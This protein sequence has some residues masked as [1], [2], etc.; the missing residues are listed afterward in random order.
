MRRSLLVLVALATGCTLEAGRGFAT[1]E[2]GALHASLELDSEH[3]LGGWALRTD[4]GYHVQLLELRVHAN[5][6]VLLT[7]D[8]AAQRAAVVVS[9]PI[10][11]ELD[12]LAA[13]TVELD[14]FEPSHELGLVAIERAELGLSR[15]VLEAE[16]EGGELERPVAITAD[17][18]IRVVVGA[19]LDVLIDRASPEQLSPE[20]ALHWDATLFDG[21][22]PTGVRA[23][24]RGRRRCVQT[25]RRVAGGGRARDRPRRW[26]PAR[27]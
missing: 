11:R 18:P 19:V 13:E 21:I 6:L 16:I 22:D 8:D 3:D 2:E 17:L 9:M 24:H 10:E 12:L 1:L 23:G 27:R 25:A 26:P 7:G 5:D 20:A 14:V 4:R 15:L